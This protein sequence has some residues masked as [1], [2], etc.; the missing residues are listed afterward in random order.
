MK[1]KPLKNNPDGQGMIACEPTEATHLQLRIPSHMLQDRLIEIKIGK[2]IFGKDIWSWNGDV[3][4]PTL[5]P[6][7]LTEEKWAGKPFRCHSYI[8]NGIVEFLG[9]CTHVNK[10]RTMSL[11]EVI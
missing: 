4:R 6:S 9:D 10:N 8:K 7:I 11:L 3:E 5:A 1:V 2:T